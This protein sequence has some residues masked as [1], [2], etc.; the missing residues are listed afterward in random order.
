MRILDLLLVLWPLP[1]GLY[2][3]GVL[4][5]AE[6]HIM[7]EWFKDCKG[8]MAKLVWHP[9]DSGP[10]FNWTKDW[11]SGVLEE[12][13][14]TTYNDEN[15]GGRKGFK[16]WF[17]AF[18]DDAN[19]L[20]LEI[21]NESW[22]KETDHYRTEFMKELERNWEK[23][24]EI[25]W[26]KASAK[27][28]ML[29]PVAQTAEEKNKN[30]GKGK[31]EMKVVQFGPP[32]FWS[33]SD[34]EDIARKWR[35]HKRELERNRGGGYSRDDR[36]RLDGDD[37]KRKKKKKTKKTTTFADT[38]PSLSTF[39]PSNTHSNNSNSREANFFGFSPNQTQSR[40]HPKSTKS[41]RSKKEEKN[42][43]DDDDDDIHSINSKDTQVSSCLG[44]LN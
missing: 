20:L 30:N 5:S 7:T 18:R 13:L 22:F 26:P 17:K 19:A 16:R 39:A 28:E 24:V 35:L 31:M 6:T 3:F 36:E 2:F 38:L 23:A 37:K 42:E 4:V 9:D 43:D 15:A 44:S 21:G 27:N 1:F 32:L 14:N 25:Y 40:S 33:L 29:V 10:I 12:Y 8:D 11:E 41:S 34:W